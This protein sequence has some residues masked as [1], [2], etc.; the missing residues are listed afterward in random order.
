M[1]CP[2]CG[3][4]IE[5]GLKFCPECG[6]RQHT[7]DV[8]R[9]PLWARGGERKFPFAFM[10]ALLA[11]AAAL[12]GLWYYQ[13]WK[14][15]TPPL[16]EP[17]A[18]EISAPV[19]RDANLDA[20]IADKT[21]A[22]QPASLTPEQQTR[23]AGSVEDVIENL[24]KAE[25]NARYHDVYRFFSEGLK[26][27]LK[28]YYPS[29]RI[30]SPSD[31][32][33]WRQAGA[34]EPEI[35]SIGPLDELDVAASRATAFATASVLYRGK[36]SEW[37]YFYVFTKSRSG[38]WRVDGLAAGP[39]GPAR[40]TVSTDLD[41]DGRKETIEFTADP[42]HRALRWEVVAADKS[43]AYVFEMQACEAAPNS[44]P[45]NDPYTQVAADPIKFMPFGQGERQALSEQFPVWAESGEADQ[46]LRSGRQGFLMH[47]GCVENPSYFV[48]WFKNGYRELVF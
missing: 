36:L 33:E 1:R 48:F 4:E 25:R 6:R 23:E 12:A 42:L 22:G 5:Y 39:Q 11:T 46:A 9:G 17:A 14:R 3:K 41:G 15:L 43:Q 30:S 31:Y 29:V 35:K 2:Y 26:S 19:S 37:E 8:V 34:F 47:D 13:P 32:A 21:G 24:W 45:Q 20:L 38:E 27:R 40:K 18:E 44:P 10:L 16:P 28:A 7:V